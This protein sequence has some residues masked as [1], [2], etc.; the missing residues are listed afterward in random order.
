[1]SMNLASLFSYAGVSMREDE[2]SW[3]D[4]NRVKFLRQRGWGYVAPLILDG[5]TEQNRADLDRIRRDT[6]AQGMAL[7]GWV[8]PRHTSGVPIEETL[9][10]AAAAVARYGLDGLRYQCE[11]EFEYSNPA[12]GGTPA[13]RFDAMAVL[14]EAHRRLM[15]N[16][17]AA[18]YS[19]V[20]LN[21]ADA[22]W[23][24]AWQYG[25]RCF[26][27]SYGPSE[28]GTHPGWAS[29]TAPGSASPPLVGGW[30]YRTKLGT[31][32]HLGRLND[33]GLAVTVEGQ[34]V[35]PVG[36]PAGPRFISQFGNPKWG[37]IV[38]FFPTSWIKPVEPTY[39]GAAGRPS[40]V[41]LAGEIRTFQSLVRKFGGATKGYSIYVGPEMTADHF[42]HIS[43]NVLTGAALVP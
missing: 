28:G 15:G 11:A 9:E 37:A 31:K 16:L 19:R 30:W 24:K 3:C 13:E 1:M 36:S 5:R 40:G 22:W 2:A 25:F 43:P 29:I 42:D 27:E 18:V 20:G 7:L 8:T 26:V 34:G 17:P 10:N 6:R 35:F 12:M 4:T 39:S 14:G 41:T 38:G 21:L 32:V 23:A 33:D